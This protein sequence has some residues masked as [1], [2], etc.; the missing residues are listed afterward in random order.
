MKTAISHVPSDTSLN[1]HN[2]IMTKDV[3]CLLNDVT[4]LHYIDYTD[5]DIFPT[6]T[7]AP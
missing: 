4:I 7:L 6:R 3:V 2:V 1:S 5:C